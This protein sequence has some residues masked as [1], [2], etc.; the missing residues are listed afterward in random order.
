MIDTMTTSYSMNYTIKE[1][2]A[3]SDL[4]LLQS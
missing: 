3:E 4:Q 1:F 2:Q